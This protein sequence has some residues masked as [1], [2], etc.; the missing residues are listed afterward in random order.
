MTNQP[1]AHAAA[2]TMSEAAS[3]EG[4]D[5]SE[6]TGVAWHALRPRWSFAFI[7]ATQG[8]TLHNTTFAAGWHGS[9][10][11]GVVRGAYHFFYAASSTPQ[12][13]VQNFLNAVQQQGG[14]RPGDLPPAI[15]IEETSLQGQPASAVLRN[16]TDL[17]NE[18]AAKL[19]SLTRNRRFVP[20]IYTNHDTWSGLLGDPNFARYPLW[21]ANFGSAAQPVVPGSWGEGNWLFWQYAD[22]TSGVVPGARADLD[23]FNALAE[24]AR[25]S[26]VLRVQQWLRDAAAKRRDDALDPGDPDGDFGPKTAAAVR[27]VQALDLNPDGAYGPVMSPLPE[28]GIV[29]V[30]S[31]AKLL[32]A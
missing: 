2:P 13:Q 27:R 15:D 4:F 23:R 5:V 18:L 31:W 1:T 17:I 10:G 29:D 20:L 22:T 16:F 21:I 28:T 11:A 12:A 3:A 7:E 25:G 30:V 14:F 8:G 9:A 24:G 19:G 26:E 6:A 32:W